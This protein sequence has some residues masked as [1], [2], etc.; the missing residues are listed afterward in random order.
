MG[1]EPTS[2]AWELSE[3]AIYAPLS[4]QTNMSTGKRALLAAERRLVHGTK[5]NVMPQLVVRISWRK[6]CKPDP[7][8]E[9]AG[10]AVDAWKLV[11]PFVSEE[12]L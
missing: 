1:I 5:M 7:R 11:S 8:I 6:R 10:Y 4:V 3:M 9:L 2:E 12:I